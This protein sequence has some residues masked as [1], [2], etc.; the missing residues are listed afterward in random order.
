MCNCHLPWIWIWID[1]SI[2]MQ[3]IMMSPRGITPIKTALM[4]GF[5]KWT[6]SNHADDPNMMQLWCHHKVELKYRHWSDGLQ[7]IFLYG[8]DLPMGSTHIQT[9]LIW[10]FTIWTCPKCKYSDPLFSVWCFIVPFESS[11]KCLP[12]SLSLKSLAESLTEWQCH[13]FWA[14]TGNLGWPIL[15]L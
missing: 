12:M 5:T 10:W 2:I 14:V 11:N 1:D 4:W 6:S 8:P 15:L 9:A 13:L 7:Y 3:L